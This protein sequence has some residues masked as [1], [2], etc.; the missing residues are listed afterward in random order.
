MSENFKCPK[1]GGTSF[2]CHQTVYEKQVC[3]LNSDGYYEYG[4]AEFCEVVSTDD[5]ICLGCGYHLDPPEIKEL[6]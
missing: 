5:V 6:P 3:S 4:Q 2:E 1:C